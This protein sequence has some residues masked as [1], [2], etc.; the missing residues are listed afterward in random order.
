[1][2]HIESAVFF[3]TMSTLMVFANKY[4]LTNLDFNYPIFLIMVEMILNVIVLVALNNTVFNNYPEFKI[5]T[6]TVNAFVQN[7]FAYR[8]HYLIV[9]FYSLH[10]VL[11]LKALNGLNIP[12]YKNK[13]VS[14]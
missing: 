7:P 10:A 2:L 4:V 14:K 13:A 6:R 12:M 5:D 9:F 11:S 3:G 8:F 1:M